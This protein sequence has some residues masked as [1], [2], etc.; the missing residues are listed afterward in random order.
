[1]AGCGPGF[2]KTN[3]NTFRQLERNFCEP[4]ILSNTGIQQC[5]DSGEIEIYPQP[6]PDQYT[7]SAVDLFLGSE[8]QIWN[9][10]MFQV[11][12]ASVV[13][14]LAQ[15]SF[16]LT[17]RAYLKTLT[18]APDGS[19]TFPPFRESPAHMLAI[20][21]ERV[22]LKNASRIAARV[23]G[24]SS[25]ARLGLM[26]HITAP[27]IHAGFRGAITLEMVNL[28]PFHLKLVPQRTRVCQLIFERLETQP[29]GDIVTAF[30]GQTKP[31]GAQ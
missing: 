25:L 17:A 10:E 7:T 18:P 6:G 2:Q 20:T 15:Q 16:T 24:R 3:W 11:P 23:E 8:F 1:M 12:G 26:V 4:M 30:Q 29:A 13:L 9:P 22:H 14:D 28:G 31:S 19:I 27:T 5:L 21:R